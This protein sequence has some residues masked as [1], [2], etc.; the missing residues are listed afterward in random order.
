MQVS[1]VRYQIDRGKYDLKEP[2]PVETELFIELPWGHPEVEAWL[3]IVRVATEV[4][5]GTTEV[6]VQV[7]VTV[8]VN[9]DLIGGYPG[10]QVE[11]D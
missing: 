8:K 4:N 11:H 1:R 6:G 5:G 7:I 9:V 3:P 2:V 10:A